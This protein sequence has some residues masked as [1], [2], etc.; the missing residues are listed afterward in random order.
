MVQDEQNKKKINADKIA[1]GKFFLI[2]DMNN[3]R[4]P[5][6][7]PTIGLANM[8]NPPKTPQAIVVFNVI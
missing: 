2:K 6:T 8:D 7:S 4:I 3:H 1:R 5:Q